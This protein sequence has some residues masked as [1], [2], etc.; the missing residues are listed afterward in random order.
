MRTHFRNSDANVD[1]KAYVPKC[2][3][4]SWIDF[5]QCSHRFSIISVRESERGGYLEDQDGGLF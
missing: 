1:K 4:K 2:P 5:E 3:G